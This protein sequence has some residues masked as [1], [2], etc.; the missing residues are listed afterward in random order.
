MFPM[1]TGSP[2]GN[3]VAEGCGRSPLGQDELRTLGA[4]G[5]WKHSQAMSQA[6]ARYAL[7]HKPGKGWGWDRDTDTAELCHTCSWM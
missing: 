1:A 7:L 4:T 2:E 5:L 3:W 6:S